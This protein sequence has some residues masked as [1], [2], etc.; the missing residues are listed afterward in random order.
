MILLALTFAT[1][2]WIVWFI[3]M[4]FGLVFELVT[5]Y[6]EKSRGTLPLTRVV[7]DRLMRRSKFVK[8]TV[9]F[10]LFWLLIHFILPFDW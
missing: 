7:R 9:A 2:S 5:V 4:G 6:L 8:F 3:W 10:F 1:I